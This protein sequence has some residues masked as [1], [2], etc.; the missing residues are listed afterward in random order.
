MSEFRKY[1]MSARDAIVVMAK[2]GGGEYGK[3][4][5]GTGHLSSTPAGEGEETGVIF[6]QI[7][8]L[9]DTTITS[10]VDLETNEWT[11]DDNTVYGTSLLLNVEL[12]AGTIIYGRFHTIVIAAGGLMVCYKEAPGGAGIIH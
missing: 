3:E 9:L 7:V 1:P 6:R 5:L 2:N 12:P 8:C 10:M 4:V 11:E